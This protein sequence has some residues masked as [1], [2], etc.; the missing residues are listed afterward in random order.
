MT[1][2]TKKDIKNAV[3]R[4]FLNKDRD[5]FRSMLLQYARTFYSDKIQDFSEVS[6]G[7]MLLDFAAEIG[8]NMSFYLD[9]QFTELDPEL[10]VEPQNIQRHLKTAGVQVT[11]ASP[12][13]AAV[14]WAIEVPAEV[15]GSKY[16]P[17][18]DALPVIMNGS[19]VSSEDGINFELTEDLNFA[20]KDSTGEYK[21]KITVGE[22][23]SDGSP[24]TYIMTMGG[25]GNFP[26]A[27]E[28]I[29]ISGFQ[30]TD[31]FSIPN[32]FVAFREITLSNSDVTQIISV[33]DTQGNVY[34]EVDS[35]AQDTVFKGIPNYEYYD[36]A[37]PTSSKFNYDTDVVSENMEIVPA[38]Y[39]FV[40]NTDYDT[41]LTTLRFGS[42]NA[43]TLN[44]DIIPDPSK[45]ALPLY[46][47]TTFSRFTLDP[48][49]LLGTSTLGVSPINTTIT[50]V[51]RYGGGLS[52]NV[53]ATAIN[54]VSTLKMMFPYGPSPIVARQVRA[55]VS[56]RNLDVASG[57]AS[58][59]T[60]DELRSRIPAA[61]N[62]QGR[63]VTKQDLLARVYTMPAN[64]GR[65]F[66]AGVHSNPLNPLATQL[67]VIARNANGQLIVA[68]DALK[69]NLRVF[70]NEY[71][72]ISDAIDILD[73]SVINIVVE[74]KVVAEPLATKSIVIQNII[75]SLKNY[76]NIENFSI[77]QPIRIDDI[78]NIIFN[79]P[80][81]AAVLDV[82]LRNITGAVGN[83]TYSGVKF[84][85]AGNVR[86]RMLVG[87]AGSFF[88]V[89]Y[90][91]YDIIGSA[92]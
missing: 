32:T 29:C 35:L 76:F 5:A 30:A 61:R 55:S 39:R 27:P 37:D 66:R 8:D 3:A 70:L 25:P 82:R 33:T 21:A 31:A 17:S 49:S 67:F 28:G 40:K 6:V 51:Y 56:V 74:F 16:V 10:A 48:N 62:A 79:S 23:N 1:Q 24:A 90:P 53:A 85:A 19:I 72:M 47:K 80:D 65:V 57:G 14:M 12:A 38:P 20:S 45:F 84:D 44:D 88:E 46:G 43:A 77:D 69:K 4:S 11:G 86:K 60:L 22:Y 87:P 78:H 89:R 63:I 26:R 18:F 54:T 71:R 41:K 15:D 83:R 52:H 36:T 59:P 2:D 7:G 34:Y 50:V 68:P 73:A 91:D 81:V 92:L 75:T 9:H 64:F 58:A 13:V 42:G